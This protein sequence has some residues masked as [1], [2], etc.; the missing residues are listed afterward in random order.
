MSRP[1]R[2]EYPGAW[3]HV[4]N[5]GAGQK[6]IFKTNQQREY[7]LS[8][9]SD[10]SE[11]FNAQWHAYCLMDN[12]YHLM[13][14]TPEGNLQRIMRHV[15]GVYTQYF[16]RTEKQD[17]A[18]FRGR[19]KSILVDAE[20]YWLNLSRYIH[21]NPLEANMVDSLSEYP[22]SSYPVYIGEADA[23][24][25]L[26]THYILS[27]IGEKKSVEKYKVFV[28]GSENNP[29]NAFYEKAYIN[30]VLGDVKYKKRVLS[31][32]S[33]SIDLPDINRVKPRP[34]LDDIVKAVTDYY[35]VEES[36]I[37]QSRRG[38]RVIS[39]AR[40]MT[41]YLCQRVAGMKL[42]M[43]A[44]IFGLSSYASASSSIRLIRGRIEKENELESDLKS[45]LLVLTP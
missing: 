18:L 7:F 27:A 35:R 26:H 11:R 5:R 1:L 13:V 2:I 39:H 42:K 24:S 37:W 8:L 15:N 28:E 34:D 25:W 41:M 43:I 38:Y 33:E 12:H 30:P 4:M 19:Y 14:R 31:G 29:L 3:Y 20:T 9:L 32:L 23:F 21:C 40:L 44:E 17:G 45:I 36:V 6:N 16:N 22:W 10:T